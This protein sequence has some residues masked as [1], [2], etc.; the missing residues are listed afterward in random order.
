MILYYTDIQ[1]DRYSRFDTKTKSG[2]GLRLDNIVECARWIAKEIVER[3]PEVVV[4][5]GDTYNSIGIVASES[6]SATGLC[7]S[8]INKACKEVGAKHFNILGNHDMGILSNSVTTIDHLE[9]LSD[10]VV[11]KEPSE[12]EI[13]EYSF[14]MIPYS[15]DKLYTENALR[16][17][18]S[19]NNIAFTHLDF[20]GFKFN[21]SKKSESELS[22]T[23]FRKDFRIINGHYHINQT[24][25]SVYCPGSCIQHKYTEFSRDRGIVWIDDKLEF[26]FIENKISPWMVKEIIK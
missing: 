10:M 23:S 3:K 26:H 13:G 17:S 15:G 12:F 24:I 14:G 22:P 19:K 20:N 25:G 7:M 9:F 8:I 6:L 11:I 2:Y 5:G 18:S 4:N 16:E 1:V 21:I